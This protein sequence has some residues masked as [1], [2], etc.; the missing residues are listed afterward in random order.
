[1]GRRMHQEPKLA[2]GVADFKLCAFGTHSADDAWGNDR[3]VQVL[4]Q[5][6]DDAWPRG[7]ARGADL[8]PSPPMFQPREDVSKIILVRVELVVVLS[9][10]QTHMNNDVRLSWALGQF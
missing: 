6:S 10:A 5:I 9:L 1:M 2:R 3:R 7:V 4:D 8:D